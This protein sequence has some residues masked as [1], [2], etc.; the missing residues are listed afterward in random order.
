[1]LSYS[2]GVLGPLVSALLLLRGSSKR[3]ISSPKY[4]RSL[5]MSFNESPSL[6]IGE[7][8]SRNVSKQ[9]QSPSTNIY[10][11]RCHALNPSEMGTWLVSL[12][13][14]ASKG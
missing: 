4:V 8:Y 7:V 12:A 14:T 9:L 6:I 1:M 13:E 3:E 2:K 11:I 5:R 10:N